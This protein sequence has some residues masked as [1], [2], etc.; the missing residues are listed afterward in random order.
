[1]APVPRPRRSDPTTRVALQWRYM[2]ALICAAILLSATVHGLAQMAPRPARVIAIGDIHGA[3]D[4]FVTILQR[5]GLINERLA[6]S[7]GRATLVQ[8]GDY[9]DRGTDVRKVLDLLMRL[10]REASAAGG[11]VL[12]LLGNHE[13]MNLIGDWRDVTPEI[14]ATFATPKSEARREEAYRDYTRLR[15]N[16]TTPPAPLA[17]TREEWMVAHPPGCLEYREAMSPSG[18]YGRWLRNKAIAARVS[19]TL[20]M[21]AGLNPSRAVPRALAEINDRAR[22][23]IRRLDAHR[24]RL[25][26]RRLV[27]A[28]AT[29]S[30]ILEVSATEL[31]VASLALAAA[32]AEGGPPP[33]LDLPVLRE[34][35]DLMEVRTWS[36]V[37]PEGPLWF[38]GYA[39]WQDPQAAPTVFGFLDAMKLARIV[40]AHTVTPSRKITTRF[41][42]RVVLIDTGM[43]TSTYSGAPAALELTGGALKAIYQN[44]EV[45]LSATRA[46]PVPAA[47]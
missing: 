13:V 1:M 35:N 30:D 46:T 3:Y 20:F 17:L 9:T 5:A 16:S 34:A 38:R 8:T 24:Q 45:E 47:R 43:L 19:D 26:S 33:Q 25:T 36:V 10:E 44:E 29:L 4:E 14:C 2:R 32:K 18:V 37:D 42:G 21:H 11:Q 28:T 22:D 7:G 15:S 39:Q 23:E 12:S 6:W 40:V 27:P 41:D 31:R